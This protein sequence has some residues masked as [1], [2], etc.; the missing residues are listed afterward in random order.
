MATNNP[1]TEDQYYNNIVE[2]RDKP[3]WLA[4]E[5]ITFENFTKLEEFENEAILPCT[6]SWARHTSR[7]EGGASLGN[8]LFIRGF[9][10][11]IVDLTLVPLDSKKLETAN[12]AEDYSF[13]GSRKQSILD[14]L[15]KRPEVFH[16]FLVSALLRSSGIGCVGFL[17]A[18]VVYMP[19]PPKTDAGNIFRR[20]TSLA[21][22]GIRRFVSNPK[23]LEEQSSTI[24]K[25]KDTFAATDRHIERDNL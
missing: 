17:D 11:Q 6:D 12:I 15:E 18:C 5:L 4:N 3:A 7:W 13:K 22:D 1:E 10:G 23:K 14:M 20:N 25:I 16:P 19:L 2:S 8:L 21:H 24:Q 9:N